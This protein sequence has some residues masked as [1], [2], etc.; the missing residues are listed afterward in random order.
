MR[1]AKAVCYQLSLPG[2]S[3]LCHSPYHAGAALAASPKASPPP[4]PVN[5]AVHTSS[6]PVELSRN[7]TLLSQ[8]VC[9]CVPDEELWLP[10]CAVLS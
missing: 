9:V 4:S 8:Q 10:G 6:I 7:L 3:H 1:I 5:Y 2:V